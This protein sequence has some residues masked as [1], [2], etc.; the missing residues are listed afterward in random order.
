VRRRWRW[1]ST[2]RTVY[3][4]ERG[5]KASAVH[6]GCSSYARNSASMGYV[7][8]SRDTYYSWR[9]AGRWSEVRVVSIVD[10]GAAK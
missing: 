2:V 4:C 8:R 5:G 10:S 6:D 1:R 7:M 3:P 9:L